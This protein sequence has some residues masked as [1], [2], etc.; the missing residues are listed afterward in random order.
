MISNASQYAHEAMGLII[1]VGAIAVL[2]H[3]TAYRATRAK[4]YLRSSIGG[5]LLIL[6]AAAYTF[7]DSVVLFII[8][9]VPAAI[10]LLANRPRIRFRHDEQPKL[11]PAT[12]CPSCGYDLRGTIA[13]GIDVCP[14]CGEHVQ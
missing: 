6:A 13:A 11:E 2:A 7:A 8:F 14:E 10:L 1:L 9:V 5:V 4:R 3:L 12:P